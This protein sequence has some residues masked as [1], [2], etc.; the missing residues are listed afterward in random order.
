[1]GAAEAREV[2]AVRVEAGRVGHGEQEGEAEDE[3]DPGGPFDE[4]PQ[5]DAELVRDVDDH[6]V[7]EDHRQRGGDEEP[8]GADEACLPAAPAIARDDLGDRRA[9]HRP[10]ARTAPRP[11][12]R[13]RRGWP[14]RRRPLPRRP[15]LR[16]HAV[17]CDALA[18]KLKS[19]LRAR[20]AARRPR[21][22]PRPPSSWERTGARA[23]A[24]RRP[25]TRG[26]PPRDARSARDSRT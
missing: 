5:V 19:L 10:D 4:V 11:G 12:L 9:P 7:E 13:P 8:A 25:R 3:Q 23:H 2:A 16:W 14:G 6:T 17:K 20:P 21:A 26:T 24:P 1:V 22:P 15:I 18:R